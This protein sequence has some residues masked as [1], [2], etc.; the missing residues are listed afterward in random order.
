MWVGFGSSKTRQNVGQ[1]QL[2][3]VSETEISFE[4][5]HNICSLGHSHCLI[6]QLR[7]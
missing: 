1:V 6:V 2:D 5:L 7:M 4:F 3:K